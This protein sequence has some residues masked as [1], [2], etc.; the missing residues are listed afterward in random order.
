MWGM[1]THPE[2]PDGMAAPNA[3]SQAVLVAGALGAK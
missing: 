1:M 3:L 2:L